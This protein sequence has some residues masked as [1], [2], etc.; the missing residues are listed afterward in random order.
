MHLCPGCLKK[1]YVALPPPSFDAALRYS[2]LAEACEGMGIAE[3]A[4]FR[5]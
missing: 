5:R 1:L 3:A 4:W 2:R